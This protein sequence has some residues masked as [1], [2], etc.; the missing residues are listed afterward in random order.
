[1]GK[2]NYFK[3]DQIKYVLKRQKKTMAINTNVDKKKTLLFKK[4]SRHHGQ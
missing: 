4:N 1:M 3:K 2:N